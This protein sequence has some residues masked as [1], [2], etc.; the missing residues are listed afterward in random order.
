M[1]PDRPVRKSSRF[2][3][4]LPAVLHLAQRDH[5]CEAHDL[6]RSGVLLVGELPWPSTLEVELTLRTAAADLELRLGGSVQRLGSNPETAATN[7][8]VEFAPLDEL[9]RG[10]LDALVARVVEGVAPAAL[11]ALEP[12]ASEQEIR[13]ALAK[14]S[15]AHRI[16]LAARA[17]HPREREILLHDTNPQVLESLAR[18]PNLLPREVR[19]LLR[20]HTLVPTTLDLLGRDPRWAGDDELKVTIAAHPRTP[21]ATAERVLATLGPDGVRRALQRPGLSPALRAKLATRGAKR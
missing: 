14:V 16:A 7:I 10:V 2:P 6:S 4:G 18:N 9:R 13:D 19:A 5:P 20:L 15:L 1:A 21:P 3:A 17:T 12:G 8:A 11:S